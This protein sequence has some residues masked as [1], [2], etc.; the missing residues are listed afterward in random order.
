MLGEVDDSEEEVEE[1]E[2]E[3]QIKEKQ[4]RII[5]TTVF[6]GKS[7]HILCIDLLKVHI[8]IMAA[9][10]LEIPYIFLTYR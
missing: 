1:E 3:Q 10:A 7:L 4:V 6:W 5:C 9:S 8:H 2:T